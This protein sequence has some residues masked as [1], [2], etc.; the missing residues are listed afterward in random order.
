[1][2]KEQT[3]VHLGEEGFYLGP[4]IVE[5]NPRA[6]S[7][8]GVTSRLD[9]VNLREQSDPLGEIKSIRGPVSARIGTSSGI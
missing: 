7:V 8:R 5:V 1:M 9:G 3:K 4:S 6:D 2:L